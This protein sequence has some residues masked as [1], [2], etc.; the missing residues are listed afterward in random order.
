MLALS[1]TGA[2]LGGALRAEIL[3]RLA[4]EVIDLYSLSEASSIA[5]VGADGVGTVLPNTEV[6]IIDETGAPVPDGTAGLIK[7][8]NDTMLDGYVD[9]PEATARHFRDGWFITNDVG[10]VPAPGRLL[11]L[12]R[13]DDM[14]N[15]GGIKQLPFPIEERLRRI[16][17]VREAIVLG[18]G[19]DTLGALVELAAGTGLDPLLPEIMATLT[20]FW[21]PASVRAVAA[22]PRT[23]GDK[24]DRRAAAALFR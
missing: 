4:S 5:I 20:A 16:D 10:V 9:D 2:P 11:V 23:S 19:D 8:R 12:G 1:T 15:L 18:H 7:V 13:Y 3:R 17:G 6:A 22:M 14:L 21:R 24:P